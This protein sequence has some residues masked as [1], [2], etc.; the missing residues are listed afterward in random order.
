MGFAPGSP[1]CAREGQ[2][3]GLSYFE[4]RAAG[5]GESGVNGGK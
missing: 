2:A 5:L 1:R 4:D 3:G